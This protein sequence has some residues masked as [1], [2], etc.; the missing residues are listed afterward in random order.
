MTTELHEAPAGWLYDEITEGLAKGTIPFT[1][2]R[3]ISITPSPGLLS[4]ICIIYQ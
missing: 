3:K 2:L 4:L 1:W